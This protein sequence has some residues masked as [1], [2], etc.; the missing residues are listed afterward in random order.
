MNRKR[1]QGGSGS[2]AI[3]LSPLSQLD[4][5]RRGAFTVCDAHSHTAAP[6]QEVTAYL[7]ARVGEMIDK[8]ARD[9]RDPR[10]PELPL[11][12]LRVSRA[13]GRCDVGWG[14]R[15]ATGTTRARQSCCSCRCV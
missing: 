2:C 7:Q 6:A 5:L 8:A 10:T 4:S 15:H 12:R 11:V 13:T 9:R 3:M 14:W 1:R